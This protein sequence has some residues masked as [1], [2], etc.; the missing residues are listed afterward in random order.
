MPGIFSLNTDRRSF[1]KNSTIAGLSVALTG[2]AT[3]R[4]RTASDQSLFLT[5]LSDT[6][7]PGDPENGYR[8]FKP[9]VNLARILP[10]IRTNLPDGVILNGDAARLEGKVED[11]ARLRV[12]LAPL[13]KVAPIYIGLGN[14]D[15]RET[16]LHAFNDQPG[17]LPKVTGKHV[18]IIEQPQ[19]RIIQLDSLLYT[20]KTAGLLGHAQ[21]DWLDNFLATSDRR[22]T[23]L[24]VHHTL[25][26]GDGELLDADRLFELLKPYGQVKAIF[27]GHSH[28]WKITERQN[29]KLINLPAVGYNFSDDQPVGWVDARFNPAGVDLTLHTIGGNQAENGHSTSLG[30][31]F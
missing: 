31:H 5:L 14:H 30:W 13:A 9:V 25:G 24:F 15:E 7:I 8:G 18:I 16:F 17:K 29:I 3:N 20:N 6:H 1:I 27:Y 26:D 12:M 11:Y 10:E 4:R 2:C 22:P 23:I 28:V 21:R 19:L